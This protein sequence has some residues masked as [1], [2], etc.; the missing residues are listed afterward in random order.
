MLKSAVSDLE[1]IS[2]EEDGSLWHIRYP[3]ADGSGERFS[4]KIDARVV[5]AEAAVL[6]LLSVFL[7]PVLLGAVLVIPAIAAYWR[8]RIG[9]ITGDCLG[10]SVEVTETILLLLIALRMA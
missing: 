5:G 3:L 1:V 2:E 4:W 6:A 7:A 9:G 8:Y 10:A